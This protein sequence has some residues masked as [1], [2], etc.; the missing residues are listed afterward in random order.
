MSEWENGV[1]WAS[2]LETGNHRIDQQHKQLFKLTSDI[3]ESYMSGKSSELV[4]KT[5]DFLA[6][7]TVKHFADEE[8]LQI[9]YDFP[10]YKAH[11]KMHDDFKET[12]TDLIAKY[13]ANDNSV[14]LHS[15]VN[16]IVVRWLVQHIQRE[17]SKI[18][19]HIRKR[20]V[21]E[22]Y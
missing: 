18:A 12:V 5:L 10:E 15:T 1:R 21:F 3:V 14:D 16:S 8:A 17:D 4:A 6:E 2:N 19:Q 22:K 13:K 11:K 20:I 7:Y 9:Q